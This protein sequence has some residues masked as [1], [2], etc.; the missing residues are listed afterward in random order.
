MPHCIVHK[1]SHHPRQCSR[2]SGDPNRSHGSGDRNFGDTVDPFL[3]GEQDVIEVDVDD[4]A[5]LF[6]FAF[7]RACENQQVF[8]QLPHSARLGK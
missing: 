6:E 1:V 8:D 2:V 7:V 5:E 4:D 3:L